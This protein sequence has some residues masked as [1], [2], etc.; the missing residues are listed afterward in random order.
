MKGIGKFF[1]I[2]VVMVGMAVPFS[3]PVVA[4]QSLKLYSTNGGACVI[5]RMHRDQY[6]E[7]GQT[8]PRTVREVLAKCDEYEKKYGRSKGYTPADLGSFTYNR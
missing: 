5:A 8:V 2:A 6:I 7:N 3:S 4:E 1:V